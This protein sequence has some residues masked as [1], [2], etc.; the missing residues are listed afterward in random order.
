MRDEFYRNGHRSDVRIFCAYCIGEFGL[1]NEK[2]CV[3]RHDGGFLG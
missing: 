1:E 2:Y 3:E